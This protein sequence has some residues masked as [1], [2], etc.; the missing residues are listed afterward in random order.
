MWVH[1]SWTRPP[2][3]LGHEWKIKSI[4]WIA[5]RHE[6]SRKLFCLLGISS[7]IWKK[8][9]SS[10]ACKL[11]KTNSRRDQSSISA[12]DQKASPLSSLRVLQPM[13]RGEKAFKPPE[14]SYFRQQTCLMSL[15]SRV[16]Y[17]HTFFSILRSPKVNERPWSP[18][19]TFMYLMSDS[20]TLV[21]PSTTLFCAPLPIDVGAK[22][23]LGEITLKFIFR[24]P[25]A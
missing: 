24:S 20:S 3:Q 23:F 11:I 21:I 13:S 7:V 16:I 5:S 22:S 19:T 18:P 2:G 17:L 25:R 4:K 8:N 14:S 12:K 9:V 1:V 10:W 6:S 15:S